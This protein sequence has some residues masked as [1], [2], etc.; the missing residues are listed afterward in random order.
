MY[1]IKV[2]NLSKSE[3]NTVKNF[4]LNGEEIPEKQVKLVDNGRI[5]EIAV[6]I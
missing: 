4:K 2:R 6:E 1:N 5:Y 3:P